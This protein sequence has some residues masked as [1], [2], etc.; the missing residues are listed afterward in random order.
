M[1]ISPAGQLAECRANYYYY[2]YVNIAPMFFVHPVIYFFSY[3]IGI[4]VKYI[5]LEMI[6]SVRR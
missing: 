1:V 4:H 5:S 3:E 2:Y 6:T